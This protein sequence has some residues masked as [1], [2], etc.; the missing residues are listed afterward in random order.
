MNTD[1]EP[2]KN[3][4]SITKLGK[5]INNSAVERN[6]RLNSCFRDNKETSIKL[7]NTECE[8]YANGE[9]INIYDD[10][11]KSGNYDRRYNKCYGEMTAAHKARG[12]H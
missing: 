11:E 2:V 9:K 4:D 10:S 1:Y 5:I 7:K 8:A 12:Y 6:K 3:A